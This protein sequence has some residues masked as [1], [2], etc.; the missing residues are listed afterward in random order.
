[1]AIRGF[2]AIPSLTVLSLV[3]VSPALAQEPVKIDWRET[4]EHRIGRPGLL[5]S[6]DESAYRGF[7][8]IRL[9]V[10]V[11]ER[12]EVE[13]AQAFSGQSD[14][15][16]SAES[17]EAKTRFRPFIRD[18]LPVRAAVEDAI[19]IV[20][21]ET[22][23]DPP[24]PFPEIRSRKTLIMH[25]ERTGCFGSCPA[26]SVDVNGNGAVYYTGKGNVLING[27]HQG[28]ISQQGMDALVAEFRKANY[29]SLKDSYVA[30]IT[31]NPAYTTSIEFDGRKKSVKDYVG[32]KAGMPV[33]AN[34]L[35]EAFDQISGTEKWVKGNDQTG[36]ALIAEKWDFKADTDDNRALFASVVSHGL[37]SLIQLFVSKGAPGVSMTNKG[38]SA[39]VS[40]AEQG[41]LGLVKTLLSG[42]SKPSE[43]VL[44]CAL[45]SAAKSGNLGLVQYLSDRRADVNG[46]PCGQYSKM[47]VLMNAVQSGKAEIVQEILTYH[48]DVNAKDE[49]GFSALAHFLQY[50][51]QESDMAKILDLLVSS[52]AD[53]NSRDAQQETPIFYACQNQHL[54]SIRALAKAGA[55][56]NAKGQYGETAIMSCF[57]N[58]GIQAL[59][60]AGADV[61]IQNSRGQTAAEA[62][63]Q[64]G[65]KDK[66]DLLD[67]ASKAKATKLLVPPIKD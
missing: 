42:E 56:L 33:V 9:H 39:L 51:P 67:T 50:A 34:I 59:I 25:L 38:A 46:P 18:G 31:D 63:L 10:I 4:Y 8:E 2:H 61:S 45:G 57:G 1:M 60:D 20:P 37:D 64:M 40:A 52:G 13:S 43:A 27:R 11:N 48:P 65:A 29:F 23:L 66:A 62:A 6:N 47:T 55:D 58:R 54:E 28:R 15:L 22:W 53:V 30:L 21:P 26:Y 41:N 12:G 3:L 44:S 14:L 19:T 5:H 7:N 49:R 17:M 16:A 32:F 35:E 36:P 24:V